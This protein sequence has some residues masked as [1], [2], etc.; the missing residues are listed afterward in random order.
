MSKS[1]KRGLI[2]VG[3]VVIVLTVISYM[4]RGG[5]RPARGSVLDL[6]IKDEIPEQVATDTLAQIVGAKKLSLRDYL[7]ALR[8]ARDDRRISGL[9]MSVDGSSL[10]FAQA[11]E[12]RDAILDF[13]SSGK[14]CAAYL[15]TAG[16]FAPGNKEYYLATACRTI[17]LAPPGDINLTGLRAEVPFVRGTLDKLGIIPD[18]D[19]IGK[20]KTAMNTLTE[21]AMTTAHKESME[22]ILDSFYGQFR[23]GIAQ[24]RALTDDQVRALVDRGPFIGPRAIESKLVDALGY[25]DELEEHLKEENGGRLPLVKVGRYLKS[26]RYYD[27]GAKVALIYGLGGVS[28][29][30]SDSNPVTGSASMGSDT[31]AAAIKKAREDSSIKAI[32]FRVDSPGG[33]YIAS[34]IIWHEVMRTKGVKPIVVSMSDVAGSGGYFVAMGA[35]WIIAQP[36]TI[37]ASIGVLAGKM[38]TT[39]F[40]DK[41]GITFDTV[42]RGRHASFYATGARYTP[43][44]RA[45]FESWLDR[46]YRDF[47]GKAAKG[48]HKSY[49]EIDAIAQG[50]IWSGEDALRLGLVDE[51]GGLPAAI[52]RA[53][54][55]AKL[56]PKARV[57]LVILP[58]PKSFVQEW[59]SSGEESR[60]SVMALREAA[61][62]SL[63]MPAF[64][65]ADYVLEMPFVPNVH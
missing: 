32:V 61:A 54:E 40:W 1:A 29:G 13:E 49:Q 55:L 44:E 52:R 27:R 22:A 9:L 8:R 37:T 46:I 21:K 26:G 38:I 59:F 28:R 63:E 19:H 15:E 35:D 12:L 14:W 45:I 34:D 53:L 6:S 31:I 10:G 56:S 51:L 60:V 65:G 58:E 62:K 50:R 42:Q 23:R 7:E 2:I 5:M 48:R 20:Y 43:E 16:E 57:R 4:V 39:G 11:Q 25:R 18:F 33:S 17:W 41:L 64:P 36:G 24:G 47:V 3:A 30:E